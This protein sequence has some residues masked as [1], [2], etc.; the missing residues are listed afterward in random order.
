MG[1]TELASNRD[2]FLRAVTVGGRL[3]LNWDSYLE[4]RWEIGLTILMKPL[5]QGWFFSQR[6]ARLRIGDEGGPIEGDMGLHFG[7][8]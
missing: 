2:I 7:V 5:F 4:E 1:E 8:G 6:W 3:A